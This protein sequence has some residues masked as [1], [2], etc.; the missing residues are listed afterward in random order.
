M[1]PQDA[2]KKYYGYD[3]F[4]PGQAEIIQA[5]LD[6]RDVL[7]ILPTG[8]GKSLCYQIP[9][10]CMPGMTVVVSPLISLMKDQVDSLVEMGVAARFINSA[11]DVEHFNETIRMAR[12]GALDLLYV[13]PERL[14]NESFC[15]LLLSLDVSMV[16]VDE[17]HCV[18]QWG[19]DFRPSYMR[20]AEILNQFPR[21]PI[22]A[23]FTATATEEVRV[24][25]I[26]Q[27]HLQQ[28]FCY[29]STFDRGNL[30][31]SVQKPADKRHALLQLLDEDASSIIY[32]STRKNVES[33]YHFLKDRRYPVTYYHAGLSQDVRA[34]HQDDFIYDRA[35]IMVATNAFGMG[36]DK[37]DVRSVIHYN[38]PK[39]LE[40]YYQEAGRAGRD[41]APANAVLLFSPQDIMINALHIKDS[42][43][44]NAQSNLQTMVSYCNTGNCLRR[45]ILHYFGEEPQWKTCGHCSICDGTMAVTDC[46]VEAQKI[47]SCIVRMHQRYGSG[48]VADV[49]LGHDTSFIRENH[50]DRLSTYG[51]MRDYTDKDI[52]DII[53]LLV[54][55][56]YLRVEG[57]GYAILKLTEHSKRILRGEETIAINKPLKEP[58]RHRMSQ[59]V[60]NIRA[61]DKALFQQLRSTRAG[62]ADTMGVP[63]F[64]I[65]SDRSLIDMAAKLPLNDNEMRDVSGVGE[66]K[67][68]RY[69]TPFIMTVRTYVEQN[70]VDV[71][72]A[73]AENFE[74]VKP[75]SV[76]SN[77]KGVKRT[78]QSRTLE[79]IKQGMSI[80]S[81][82]RERKLSLQTIQGHVVQLV[83]NGENL[84]IE[85]WI[86][87]EE[88]EMIQRTAALSHSD[89][90]TPI[91]DA[92]PEEISFFQI[93]L[94]LALSKR[95]VQR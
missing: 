79:L 86:T 67:L 57:D 28:P 78:T 92:L 39:D 45:F 31:F 69:G 24:D 38:M 37:P 23:A 91:K 72:K 25:I 44:P 11:S 21:R 51:V 52:R 49:L 18:S 94:A 89:K 9:A 3:S 88:C 47:L 29:V 81:I 6:G 17:A 27:L 56:G 76:G 53:S 63:P 66:K 10:I 54:A 60:E 46:T 2:L 64:V 16:A 4:R 77:N 55:K 74:S 82:A 65:F 41:G 20:I 93:K 58:E 50:F 40:S 1:K 13:A 73:R 95:H 70:H 87:Q 43:A 14:D 5:L 84:P 48:K 32:C 85:K 36:I 30:Y 35:P 42:T 15:R 19:H 22:F 59:S 62:I 83:E 8:G 7:A 68:E 26:N 33:V 75:R 61:Y 12:R 71:E 80:D 90:L 34:K